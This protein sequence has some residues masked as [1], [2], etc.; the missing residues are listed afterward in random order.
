VQD[1]TTALLATENDPA[2]FAA[3]LSPLVEDTALRYSYAASAAQFAAQ[4]RNLGKAAAAL[5]GFL[6]PLVGAER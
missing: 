2:D 6:Q 3:K 1:R 5:D 4:E